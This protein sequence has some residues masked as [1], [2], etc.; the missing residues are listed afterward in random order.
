MKFELITLVVLSGGSMAKARAVGEWRD[1]DLLSSGER[2]ALVYAE[3][4]AQTG[5]RWARS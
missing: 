5:N 4:I 1:S 2:L 3:V